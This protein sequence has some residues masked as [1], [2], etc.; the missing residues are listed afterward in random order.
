MISTI[1]QT[2]TEAVLASIYLFIVVII[3][4]CKAAVF[5]NAFFI[6]FVAT[7]IADLVSF[8]ANL[9]LRLNRELGLSEAFQHAV[10][11]CMMVRSTTFLAHLIGNTLL[12]FNRYSA[13]CLVLR[14][15]EIWTRRNIAIAISVQYLLAVAPFVR[16][17][18]AK[19]LYVKNTDGT[20]TFEGLERSANMGLFMFAILT[21]ISTAISCSQQLIKGFAIITNNK[22]LDAWATMQHFWINDVMVSIPP[23]SLLLLCSSLRK[24]IINLLCRRKRQVTLNTTTPVLCI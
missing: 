6:I 13:V 4:T 2:A 7:G 24:E 16:L 19:L 12:A 21:F 15:H 8:L 11:F 10:L 3:V 22:Q 17:I 5:R 1:S 20:V 18:G 23:F 9:F 14:Y